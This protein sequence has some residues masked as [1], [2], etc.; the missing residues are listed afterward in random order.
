MMNW[1]EILALLS[2]FMLLTCVPAALTWL[3]YQS[4]G[5]FTPIF[6]LFLAPI[7]LFFIAMIVSL[8]G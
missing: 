8:K 5:G 2:I 6:L 7:W 1:F 4:Q 3:L